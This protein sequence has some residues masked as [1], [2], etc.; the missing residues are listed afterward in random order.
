MAR[1]MKEND[2][3][4]VEIDGQKDGDGALARA[5]KAFDVDSAELSPIIDAAAFGSGGYPHAKRMKEKPYERDLWTL[6]IE[7]LKVQDWVRTEGRR[8]VVLFEGRDAAGKGGAIHRLTQHL[9]PRTARVV[10]LAKPTDV[11]QGQWYF[12]RY[13]SHL[14]TK[15]EMVIFDRSWYNRAGVE[16]VM[17]FCTQEESEHFLNAVGPFE[18]ALAGDGIHL[19]KIFLTIGHAMQL[20]RLHARHKDPL[21]RWKLS[22]IDYQAVGKWDAYS[23][24]LDEML[25]KSDTPDAPWSIIKANDKKRTR[26]AVI[27]QILAHLPYPDKDEKLVG[28]QDHKIVQSAE[29]FLRHGGEV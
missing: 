11:E 14:P 15:G 26:L 17:G 24:A 12:Q 10:A 27:R 5:I 20:K 21:K 6:Q 2:G 7:L 18:S 1:R 29:T 19:I 22:P 4:A 16:R 3:S 9:N 8:I 13:V 25:G 28:A 23:N